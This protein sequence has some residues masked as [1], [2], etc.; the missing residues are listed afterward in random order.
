FYERIAHPAMTDITIDWGGFEVTEM[1]PKQ[2]PDLWVGQPIR[3]VARYADLKSLEQAT[4]RVE[5]IVG[6]EPFDLDVEMTLAEWQPDHEAVASLW[7][8][9]KIRD[10]SWYP[11]DRSATALRE[12]IVDVAISHHLVSAYTSLVAI[13]DER[14]RCG[15]ARRSVSIP[16]ER[17]PPPVIRDPG[18]IHGHGYG[19]GSGGIGYGSGSGSFSLRGGKMNPS[20]SLSPARRSVVGRVQ[21]DPLIMGS[22]DRS[23]ISDVIVQNIG[24]F[25][26]IFERTLR[27][28]PN[29]AGRLVIEAVIGPDGRV[30]EA[31][32]SS[33]TMNAPDVE[34]EMVEQFKKLQFPAPRGGGEVAIRYPF[35]FKPSD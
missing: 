18:A 31:R 13:D 12:E 35:V 6:T 11:G 8:R 2:I 24:S 26:A 4:V 32:A 7:A 16:Q 21:A 1:F 9:R 23:Q 3:L 14:S 20:V 33:S 34:R 15:P 22:L 5:G 25:R 28:D 29:L 27:M 30:I 10:L 19:T 17:E